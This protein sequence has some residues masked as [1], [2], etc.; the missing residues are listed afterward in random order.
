MVKRKKVV[1]S[2]IAR[3]SSHR[4]AKSHGI[5]TV[6]LLF[7]FAGKISWSRQLF[8]RIQ[9]PMEI[10]QQQQKLLEN[11]PE[12]KKIIKNFNKLAKVLLEFEVLYYRGW[13][14]QVGIQ[15]TVS[16]DCQ[17]AAALLSF[18]SEVRKLCSP[19]STKSGY[20]LGM[21]KALLV[22]T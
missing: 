1:F 20:F 7:C 11:S 19:L 21:R 14:R 13:L 8:R 16:L 18:C 9:E 6:K 2:H 3:P 10:F 4:S 15:C 22:D 17:A 5:A 12:S